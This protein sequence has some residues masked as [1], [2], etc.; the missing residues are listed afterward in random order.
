M[1]RNKIFSTLWWLGCG[2][3]VLAATEV[4][5]WD[6]QGFSNKSL[7]GRYSSM[8]IG[9]G[10]VVP[11]AGM[12]TI[13][14]DGKGNFAGKTVFN[15]PKG[16]YGDRKVVTFPIEGTYEVGT[17]GAGTI[18]IVPPKDIGEVQSGHFMVTQ[19][20]I[21]GHPKR[22]LATEVA[23]VLDE[24]LPNAFALQTATLKRMSGRGKFSNASLK[25]TYASMGIGRGGVTPAAGMTTITADGRGTF[26]GK[27]IFNRPDGE[28][29]ERAVVTFPIKGKYHVKKDGTGTLKIF[30]P[31]DIGE[32]Q[33][34][35]F[36]ITQARAEGHYKKRLATELFFIL[37]ELLLNSAALQTA[38]LNRLPD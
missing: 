2:L 12:T 16:G 29:G 21:N 33:S 18:E 31:P 8:G 1:R 25:G 35:H 9:R 5:A 17:D 30:L 3:L 24:L 7:K 11:A 32:T 38:E 15:R 36:M 20:R 19:A 37:D 10:G 34:G 14:A 6:Q 28:Y 26:V 23:F 27:T 4:T 13:I 22:R